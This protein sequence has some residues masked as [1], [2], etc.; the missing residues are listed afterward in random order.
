MRRRLWSLTGSSRRWW[1]TGSAWSGWVCTPW[2]PPSSCSSPPRT[3][4]YPEHKHNLLYF[5]FLR[6]IVRCVYQFINCTFF[7]LCI[8]INYQ[9]LFQSLNTETTLTPALGLLPVLISKLRSLYLRARYIAL[10]DWKS[11][12]QYKFI[13]LHFYMCMC[14][15]FFQEYEMSIKQSFKINVLL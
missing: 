9:A 14:T 12:Q 1:L 6:Q 7:S 5:W 11:I 3:S 8:I 4:S 10:N 13:F 2:W 15:M